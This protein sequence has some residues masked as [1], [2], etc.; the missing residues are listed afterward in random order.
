MKI[1]EKL[2]TTISFDLFVLCI[3]EITENHEPMVGCNAGRG[4]QTR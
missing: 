4:I 3:G 1:E 2:I